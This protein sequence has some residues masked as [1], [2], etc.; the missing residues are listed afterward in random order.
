MTQAAQRSRL[1]QAMNQPFLLLLYIDLASHSGF[2]QY[3]SLARLKRQLCHRRSGNVHCE[4][5]RVAKENPELTFG[6]TQD[7]AVQLVIAAIHSFRAPHLDRC[8]VGP[9]TN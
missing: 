1:V 4:P 5:D 6:P 3:S 2:P 9:R 7:A 8:N